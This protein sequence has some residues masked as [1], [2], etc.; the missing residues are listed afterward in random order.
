VREL[1]AAAGLIVE[2]LCSSPN[3]A[4]FRLGDPRLLLV[5]RKQP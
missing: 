1:F 2:Q 3:G 4:P 5:A